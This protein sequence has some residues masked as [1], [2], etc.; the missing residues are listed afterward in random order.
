MY[1]QRFAGFSAV[2]Y[3]LNFRLLSPMRLDRRFSAPEGRA[4]NRKSGIASAPSMDHH[5]SEIS[6]Q[7]FRSFG[8]ETTL[9]FQP[10][11]NVICGANGAGKS[12]VLDAILFALA[13]DA[14]QVRTKSWADL[15]SRARGG[16]CAATLTLSGADGLTL[17]AHLKEESSRVF[18]MDGKVATMQ[19]VRQALQQRGLDTMRPSFC[20]RQH[21]AARVLSGDDLG[22]LLQ[23]ASGASRWHAAVSDS[24][25]RL[26]KEQAA[27]VHVREDIAELEQLL[28]QDR[29]AAEALITLRALHKRIHRTQ[30]RRAAVESRLAAA[31][32]LACSRRVVAIRQRGAAL[33]DEVVRHR[34][35]LS[36]A[37]ELSRSLR[38]AS[39][40]E[41]VALREAVQEVRA[42]AAQALESDV[43]IVHA[44]IQAAL[45]TTELAGLRDDDGRDAGLEVATEGGGEVGMENGADAA[46]HRNSGRLQALRE[47]QLALEQEGSC[48]PDLC[49]PLSPP[50]R[51][52]LERAKQE[53]RAALGTAKAAEAEGRARLEGARSSRAAS[54]SHCDAAATALAKLV[55]RRGE[56]ERLAAEAAAVAPVASAGEIQSALATAEVAAAAAATALRGAERPLRR[57]DGVAGCP[58][59]CSLVCLRESTPLLERCLDALQATHPIACDPTITWQCLPPRL[60]PLPRLV[61]SVSRHVRMVHP[62]VAAVPHHVTTALL[63]AQVLAGRHL[64]VCVTNTAED[65]VPLLRAAEKRGALQ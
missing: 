11:L 15:H 30:A 33:S 48:L 16:P 62:H 29:C 64:G 65:A 50:P 51:E 52:V 6:V 45:L 42:A 39:S 40:R 18:R 19:Q 58:T 31:A 35:L 27:L 47:E 53:A 4:T 37:A 14:A 43:A 21:A 22:G 63:R 20:I 9:R 1:T 49:T 13:V 2:F 56:A 34:R 5:L 44:T 36:T 32:A 57:F 12:N 60:A 54:T 23:Q 8:M 17:M 46:Q 7:H 28:A 38:Q 10:G 25:A 59:V 55:S 61:A 24:K 41:A 26:H 3:T